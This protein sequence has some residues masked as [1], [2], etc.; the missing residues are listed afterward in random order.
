MN[1]S[2][3]LRTNQEQLRKLKLLVHEGE[4][5][6]L[7]FKRKAA[8]PDKVVKEIIAFANTQGGIIL[9][10]VNDDK[11]VPGVKYPE[12]EWHLVKK[13][14]KQFCKPGL[15]I[16]PTFIPLSEKKF[17]VQLE[18]PR[19]AKRPHSFKID[20]HAVEYYIRHQDKCVKASV[21]MVEIIRRGKLKKD[22]LFT[23]GDAEEKLM[24][25]L[26]TTA[27][28]TLPQFQK[29]TN[30]NGVAASQKLVTLVLA[31]VL[32]ITPTEKGDIYS[33]I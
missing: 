8:H 21:E 22:I 32:K 19:S 10:G 14:M 6:Q 16:K 1:V 20:R 9:I 24:H 31:N 17:V 30:L 12:E 29:L 3:S 13:A 27:T 5:Y 33:R 4:G 23:Y 7:E 25:Y 15:F 2:E 11:T 26:V 18:I 28:I